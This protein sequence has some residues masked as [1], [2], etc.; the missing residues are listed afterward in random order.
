MGEVV[1]AHPFRLRAIVAARSKT[2][3]LDAKLLAQLQAAI[4]IVRRD[5]KLK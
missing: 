2:D 4:E 3:K 5:A 1:S